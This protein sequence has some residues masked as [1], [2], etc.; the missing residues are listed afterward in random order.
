M[1]KGDKFIRVVTSSEFFLRK[2]QGFKLTTKEQFEESGW[3]ESPDTD[4]LAPQEPAPVSAAGEEADAVMSDF[5]E[6]LANLSGQLNSTV[7][8]ILRT[9]FAGEHSMRTRAETKLAA[10]EALAAVNAGLLANAQSELATVRGQLET[11]NTLLVNLEINL[12]RSEPNPNSTGG[13]YSRAYSAWTCGELI[14]AYQKA[15]NAL[16]AD[17]EG[18]A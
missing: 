2:R 9:Y 11:A 13:N 14:R 7:I 15:A 12:P 4:E 3:I 16:A 5:D 6:L 18:D 17:G 1:R 8:S 10:A